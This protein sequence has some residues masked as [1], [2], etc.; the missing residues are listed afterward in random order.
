M[1]TTNTDLRAGRIKLGAAR[2]AAILERNDLVS[3]EIVA[4]CNLCWQGQ[5]H[6]ITVSWHESDAH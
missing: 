6:G 2:G 1:R 5:G 4:R 3:N